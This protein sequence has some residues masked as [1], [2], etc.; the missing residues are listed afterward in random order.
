VT[1]SELELLGPQH[2]AAL[3]DCGSRALD[4]WLKHHALQAQR[5]DSTRIYVVHDDLQIV[6]F[7]ALS[8]GS[9]RPA[10]A[11]T[12]VRKGLG[13]HDLPLVVLTRL[14]VHLRVHG[15]GL[16]AAL[17]KDALV[18]VSAAV[19]IVGARALHAH[20][21]DENAR[22]FYRHFGF[23]PSPIDEHSMFLLMKDLRASIGTKRRG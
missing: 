16:G 8:A 18:R 11:P 19:D 22:S 23:E 4:D 3:F 15:T 10:E 13:R 21:K 12:R 20:A 14:A 17:L 7:Y 6:G 9:V 5:A 1:I 2:R